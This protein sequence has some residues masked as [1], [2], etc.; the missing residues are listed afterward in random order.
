MEVGKDLWLASGAGQ[1]CGW[2]CTHRSLGKASLGRAYCSENLRKEASKARGSDTLGSNPDCYFHLG[3]FVQLLTKS[4]NFHP[5][6][7]GE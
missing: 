1:S 5:C 6:A 4:V 2:H 3:V 7:K